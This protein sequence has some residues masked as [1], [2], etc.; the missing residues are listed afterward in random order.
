MTDVHRDKWKAAIDDELSSLIENDTFE[1][2][3]L[4]EGKRLI[5]SR[6]VFAY[7]APPQV[8]TERFK[9]RLVA[10]GFTQRYG[11]DY[12]ETYAPVVRMDSIRFMLAYAANRNFNIAQFDVRNAFLYGSLKEDI[13]MACPPG[14]SDRSGKEMK[15]LKLKK[16]LYGLKQS[17]RCW[18]DKYKEFLFRFCLKQSKVD[19][20]I[21]YGRFHGHELY[22][23]LYVDDGLLFSSSNEIIDQF[24][25][26]MEQT[27]KITRSSGS[28]FVGMEIERDREK[29]TLKISQTAYVKKVLDR[30]KALNPKKSDTPVE[31]GQVLSKEGVGDDVDPRLYRELVGSLMYLSTISR[32]DLAFAV[33]HVARFMQTPK[34]SH[35][36]AAVKILGYLST[37]VSH[38]ITYDG[39]LKFKIDGYCDSDYAMDPDTRWSTTGYVFLASGAPIV[40][41]SQRQHLVCSSTCQ[42]EYVALASAGKE[43]EW[44]RQVKK[45]VRTKKSDLVTAIYCDNQS[46]IALAENNSSNKRTKHFEV[47]FHFI[48]ELL[49]RKRVNVEYISTDQQAADIFTKG[50]P[51]VRFKEILKLINVN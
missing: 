22:L 5:G 1:F 21:F 38:G 11:E 30:F 50:L 41:S 43:S 25:N 15:I 26:E 39:S 19:E 47:R 33:N 24:L 16:S 14:L 4:P 20:C 9:A 35:F 29:K 2:T 28:Y 46:A 17:P 27:F 23:T 12:N 40:W 18:N 10:R 31:S 36:S 45:I 7:K 49:E 3:T 44:L 37:T 13:Y 32:P 8:E 42:A 34:Q 48:R 51:R 6:Y